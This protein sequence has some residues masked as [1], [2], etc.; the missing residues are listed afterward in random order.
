MT[1]IPALGGAVRFNELAEGT[2]T[3]ENARFFA[4]PVSLYAHAI[5]ALLFCVV[6]AF[7]FLPSVRRRFPRWH[8]VAGRVLMVSGL[9][10]ALAGIW[11][12]VSYDLPAEDNW[13]LML[14]RLGFGSM[15]V[16]GIVIAYAAIRRRDVRT[17]RAWMIRAY[18]VAQGAGT[19]A[20][21]FIPLAVLGLASDSPWFKAVCLGLGWVINVVFAEWVV[22]RRPSGRQRPHPNSRP[23]RPS[24]R[25]RTRPV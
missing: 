17:H 10:G 25:Q 2:V 14:F 6:G 18:A 16:A 12:T 22:R 1:L 5:G 15:W 21:L 7:Q 11:M 24:G 13:L 19:Q 3:A 8:R 20:L 23:N 4:D 9:V